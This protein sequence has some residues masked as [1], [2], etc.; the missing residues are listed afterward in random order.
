M[1]G[2]LL[3]TEEL[4]PYHEGGPLLPEMDLHSQETLPRWEKRIANIDDAANKPARPLSNFRNSSREWGKTL[5]FRPTKLR[6]VQPTESRL[7]GDGLRE[8][9]QQARLMQQRRKADE[10][11]G[12]TMQPV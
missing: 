2:S 3:P 7:A 10:L 4:V 1:D 5:R 9:W 6:A 8:L 11:H 12:G